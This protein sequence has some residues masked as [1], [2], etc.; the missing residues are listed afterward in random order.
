MTIQNN[1]AIII[2]TYTGNEDAFIRMIVSLK[3]KILFFS[4]P[5]E[6]WS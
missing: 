5:R 4:I 6:K 1:V 3:M 2:N